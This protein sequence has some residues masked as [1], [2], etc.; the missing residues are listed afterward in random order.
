MDQ[1]NYSRNF[2]VVRWYK[3]LFTKDPVLITV[4]FTVLLTL[5]I[6]YSSISTYKNQWDELFIQLVA[7][8]HGMVF[9]I[10]VIGILFVWINKVSDKKKLISNC[11]EDIDDLRLRNADILKIYQNIENNEDPLQAE[12]KM[13]NYRIRGASWG[14]NENIRLKLIKAI[15]VLSRNNVTTIDLHNINISGGKFVNINLKRSKLNA[16]LLLDCNFDYANL[17]NAECCDTNFDGSC[18]DHVNLESSNS[19]GASFVGASLNFANLC[20][21]KLISADFKEAYLNSARFRHANCSGAD[22]TGAHLIKTDFRGVEGLTAHQIMK[23]HYIHN[24]L[25]DPSLEAS[26]KL[27]VQTKKKSVS[28][29]VDLQQTPMTIQKVG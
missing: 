27:A 16:S 1:K 23:A 15:K 10:L 4:S 26:I 9:D 17:S 24:C 18:L 21:S 20:G 3:A 6:S 8:A 28:E 14:D 5:V 19:I 29:S 12:H 22:F 7:E 25:F 13:R 2:D 11:L